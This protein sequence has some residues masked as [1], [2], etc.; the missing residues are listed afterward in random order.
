MTST[1]LNNRV[2]RRFSERGNAFL[3]ILLGVALFAALGFTVV[4][5][6]R[7][8]STTSLSNRDADLAVTDIMAQVQTLGRAVDRVRRN[9]CSEN[10]ISFEND[11]VAGYNHLG[12]V[13]DTCKVF[14]RSG[15]GIDWKSS[16]VAGL[17]FEF[18][19][20]D[21]VTGIGTSP[22]S[23]LVMAL[24]LGSTYEQLCLLYNKKAFGG[25]T[26]PTGTND[27]VATKFTGPFGDTTVSLSEA[28]GK[29]TA[30]IDQDG[31]KKFLIYSVLLER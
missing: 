2:F 25:T 8:Q 23:E 6:M 28:P 31:S 27:E 1:P 9:G 5:G 7:T 13:A 4:R 16:P 19:G 18:W 29:S 22:A 15:G 30:C 10:D 14:H 21:G 26:I 11:I 20:A 12:A 17:Q 3:F 24:P